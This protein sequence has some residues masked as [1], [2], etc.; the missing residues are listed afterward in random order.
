[1]KL[2][3]VDN[4]DPDQVRKECNSKIEVMHTKMEKEIKIIEDKYK[5]ST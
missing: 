5:V 1:M 2:R 4:E 3:L